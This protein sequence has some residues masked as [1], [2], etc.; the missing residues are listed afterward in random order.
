VDVAI[1]VDEKL[2]K[3]MK[4]LMACGIIDVRIV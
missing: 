4:M 3:D 1:I 2:W